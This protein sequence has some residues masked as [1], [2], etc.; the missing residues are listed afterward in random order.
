MLALS[1]SP[2]F[3]RV[4]DDVRLS[5]EWLVSERQPGAPGADAAALR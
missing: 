2:G 5:F 4:A 1:P 3:I